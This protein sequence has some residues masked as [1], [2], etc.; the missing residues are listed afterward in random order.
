[1]I[2]A[3]AVIATIVATGPNGQTDTIKLYDEQGKCPQGALRTEYILRDTI[4]INGC[5]AVLKTDSSRGDIV[6]LAYDD[7]DRGTIPVNAFQWQPGKKPA[8]L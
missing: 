4:L 2:L 6:L 7:G 1:M 8:S 5:Y 3:A